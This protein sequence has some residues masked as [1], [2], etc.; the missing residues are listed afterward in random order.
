MSSF[1]PILDKIKAIKTEKGF[2]NESLSQK[3]GIPLG[4]LSKILTSVI[5]DPKIGTLIAIT[6]AL[7]VDIDSLVY[8]SISPHQLKLSN[9]ETMIIKKYRALDERGKKV[10]EDALDNQYDYVKPQLEDK[11]I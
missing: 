7:E 3:S 2:T 1:K 9:T 4:T 5:K 6:E 8:D 11:A 10:V